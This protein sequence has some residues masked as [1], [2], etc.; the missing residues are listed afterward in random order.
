MIRQGATLLAMFLLA[1]PGVRAGE[2]DSEYGRKAPAIPTRAMTGSPT[3]PALGQSTKLSLPKASELD[4]EAPDQANRHGFGGYGG[5]GRGYGGFG[6]GHH[7]GGF[8]G[9]GRGYGGFG[10]YG[11]GFSSFGIGL[12]FGGFGGYGGYGG[13]GG[14]GYPGF[15]FGGYG[16]PGYG[17]GGGG[18]G[19]AFGGGGYGGGFGGGCW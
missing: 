7:Y 17:Y 3:T 10:G 14:Y 11:G 2:L 6:Y 9:Y 19:L 15:G 16:Y 4:R 13:F 18:F 5:F 8:G 1:A 12:G